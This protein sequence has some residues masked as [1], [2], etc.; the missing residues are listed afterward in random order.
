MFTPFLPHFY[1]YRKLN[2]W[3][4][5]PPS[6]KK[7]EVRFTVLESPNLLI[8][9]SRQ[10]LLWSLDGVDAAIESFHT[11][12]NGAELPAADLLQ[13]EEFRDVSGHH[14]TFHDGYPLLTKEEERTLSDFYW[15]IMSNHCSCF[16]GFL[17]Q[18]IVCIMTE[19]KQSVFIGRFHWHMLMKPYRESEKRKQ[20]LTR[21]EQ[22]TPLSPHSTEMS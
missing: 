21:K 15:N 1:P 8:Y 4:Q 19:N 22:I 20:F 14:V 17:R 16:P 10:R 7:K 3:L 13:L 9:W 11:F 2:I 5:S 6:Q 12:E 18:W